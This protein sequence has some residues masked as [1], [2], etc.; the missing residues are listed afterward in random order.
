MILKIDFNPYHKITQIMALFEINTQI[1]DSNIQKKSCSNNEKNYTMINYK[2]GMAEPGGYYRSVLLDEANNVVSFALPKSVEYETFTEKYPDLNNGDFQLNDIIEGTMINLF[3]NGDFWEISTKGSVG[4][5]YWYFRNSYDESDKKQ[6]TFREMFI[7]CLGYDSSTNINDIELIMSLPQNYVYSF[8]IQHQDNHIVLDITW[9]AIVL[10]SVFKKDGS[11][12][13]LQPLSAIKCW[14]VFQDTKVMFPLEYSAKQIVCPINFANCEFKTGLMITNLGT[15]ERV[16]IKNQE[17]ERLRQI[18]GNNPNM[19]YHFYALME[20]NQVS[21]FLDHFP[22]YERLFAKFSKQLHDFIRNIHDAYV[23]YYVQ[24]RGKQVRIP[25][26]IFPHIYKLH[27]D[28]H[29]PSLSEG[30]K[31]IVTKKVVS[32][33]INA[34]QPKEKLY[35][36]NKTV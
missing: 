36:I 29:V 6:K 20:S 4:G 14:N 23:I 32:D 15:G 33:Y 27:F 11:K 7:E 28:V 3:H 1:S 12:I 9:P 35:F 10:V 22:K 8:V 5:N 16:A 21:S 13:Q 25:S 34:M 19:Q 24:K 17:Y 2:N 26:N 30:E 31:I 18:R